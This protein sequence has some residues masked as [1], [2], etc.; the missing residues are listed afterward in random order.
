MDV[1]GE[2]RGGEGGSRGKNCRTGKGK[3]QETTLGGS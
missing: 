1:W 2:V 3:E